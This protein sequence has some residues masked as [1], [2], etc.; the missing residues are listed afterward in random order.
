MESKSDRGIHRFR[1]MRDGMRACDMDGIKGGLRLIEA[2]EAFD[3]NRKKGNPEQ[4]LPCG[5]R[6][7]KG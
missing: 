1:V 7:A 2:C 3:G 4:Q 6:E 5:S